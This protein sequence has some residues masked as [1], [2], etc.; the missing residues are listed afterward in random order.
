MCRK[1]NCAKASRDD[2]RAHQRGRITIP[3]VLYHPA[4]VL[5]KLPIPRLNEQP[6]RPIPSTQ[7]AFLP[8]EARSFAPTALRLFITF[9]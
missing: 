1:L 9:Q 2:Y 5:N 4:L 6:C 7:I 8:D 3:E